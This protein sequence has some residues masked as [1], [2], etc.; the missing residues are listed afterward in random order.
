VLVDSCEAAWPQDLVAAAV[1]ALADLGRPLRHLYYAHLGEGGR[2]DGVRQLANALE[3][4]VE[5]TRKLMLDAV[6]DLPTGETGYV[7]WAQRG[8]E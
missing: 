6:R 5:V 7:V 4:D 3:D 8:V 2:R 1:N